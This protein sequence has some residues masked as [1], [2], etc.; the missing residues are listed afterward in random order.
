ML[1]DVAEFISD[2]YDERINSTSFF[3]KDKAKTFKKIMQRANE[4]KI[5]RNV[6]IKNK[7][8]ASDEMILIQIKKFKKFEIDWYE[9]YEI[10]RKKILNIYILK[11]F[12]SSFN[13][14]LIN[15]DCM[16]LI[17]IN[18][19]ISKDWRMFK[20]R[21]KFRKHALLKNDEIKIKRKREKSQ[22]QTKP[23]S[24]VEYKFVSKNDLEEDVN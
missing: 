14:Y 1:D 12:E 10:V 22:K 11:F 21:K 13:K 15:N 17:Y 3:N 19:I 4:N 20:N 18:E 24:N 9:S 8:F 16:K 5:A 2:L 23:H 6:K 7:I